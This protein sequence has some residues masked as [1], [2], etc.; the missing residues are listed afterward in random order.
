MSSTGMSQKNVATWPVTSVKSP[1]NQRDEIDQVNALIEQL[2]ATGDLRLG[3]PLLSYPTR[4]PWPYRPRMNISGPS[5]PDV[6]QPAR[7]LERGM[8]SGG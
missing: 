1:R 4:P 5:V 3:P 6:E 8:V 7:L 2:A